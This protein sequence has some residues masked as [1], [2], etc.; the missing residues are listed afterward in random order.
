MG[1]SAFLSMET[2][3]IQCVDLKAV[4]EGSEVGESALW[5]LLWGQVAVGFLF[6]D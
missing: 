1:G 2:E 6:L 3:L 4:K 5:Q